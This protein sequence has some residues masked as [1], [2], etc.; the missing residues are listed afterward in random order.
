[1]SQLDG[2]GSSTIDYGADTVSYKAGK[3]Y[4]LNFDTGIVGPD[5]NADDGRGARRAGNAMDAYV[6]LFSDGA[7]HAGSSLTTG[8][9][10]RLESGGRTIAEGG[11]G[12]VNAE[13]PAGSGSASYRLIMETTRAATVATTSTRRQRSGRSSRRR[14]RRPAHRATPVHRPPRA[15]TCAGPHAPGRQHAHGA[16]EGGRRGSRASRDRHP[17][18]QGLLRRRQHLEVGP[19]H[20]RHQRGTHHARKAPGCGQSRVMPRVCEGH[21]RQHRD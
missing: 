21:G 15:E 14:P 6:Q 13:L 11:P 17:D 12:A 10:T 8:G 3:R 16:A 20:H 2:T 4:T 19:R 5:L 1:M 18:R 9:F 7:G